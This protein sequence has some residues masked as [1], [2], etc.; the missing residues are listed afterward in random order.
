MKNFP[1]LTA[2]GATISDDGLYRYVLWRVWDTN[3]PTA[4]FVML[5]P[6]TADYD[7]DDATIRR[8]M[9]F[10]WRWGYGELRVVNLFAY[11]NREAAKMLRAAD[12]VGPQNDRN[13][14][15]EA[16]AADLVLCAWSGWS[17]KK[18]DARASAVERLIRVEAQRTL[19]CLG[20]TAWKR[21]V[22]P[23]YQRKDLKPTPYTV[24]TKDPFHVEII[25]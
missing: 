1:K 20:L 22:H 10:S 16:K 6:S 18:V 11:R 8:C 2:K 14:L 17:H 13:I 3:L 24:V 4:L 25:D 9:D 12:S 5:N 15:A 7:S 21:P 19:M 23:L